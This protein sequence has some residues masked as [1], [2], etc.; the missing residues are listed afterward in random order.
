VNSSCAIAQSETKSARYNMINLVETKTYCLGR[1]IVDIP[2][3]ANPLERYDQYDSFI[4][5]VQENATPQDFDAAIAKTRKEYSEYGWFLTED[6]QEQKINGR[7]SKRLKG[8]SSS[9]EGH[10]FSVFGYVLDKNT[11]FLIEGNHSD[12]P[13]MTEKSNKAMQHVLK[14][15]QAR[16]ENEIPKETG[17]C[18]FK[19]FIKDDDRIFRDS[20]QTLAFDFENYPTVVLRFDAETSPYSVAQLIPRIEERFSKAGLVPRLMNKGNIRKGEKNTAHLSAQE[21]ISVERMWGRNGISALWEHTGTARDNKDPMIAFEVDTSYSSPGN[22]SSSL[23][24][25]D[26]LRLYE[27]IIQSIRKF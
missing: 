2:A 11:L 27:S 7:L 20:T 18:I 14:N 15:L 19:G 16:D 3:E 21:W 1:Y 26:A 24:R 6:P 25:V 13:E 9:D 12:T 5:K 23:R 10:P 17:Q 8:K 22:N 4:V